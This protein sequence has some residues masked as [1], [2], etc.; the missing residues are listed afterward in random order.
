M[1]NIFTVLL[2]NHLFF[3]YVIIATIALT[4]AIMCF[5]EGNGTLNKRYFVL[6]F[7]LFSSFLYLLAF[8]DINKDLVLF[9][10]NSAKKLFSAVIIL[11][12]FYNLYFARKNKLKFYP[13]YLPLIL[14]AV[15]LFS[16]F[17]KTSG[18]INNFSPLMFILALLIIYASRY[19]KLDIVN[20]VQLIL[21]LFVSSFLCYHFNVIAAEKLFEAK[22]LTLT[23]L[24]IAFIS[25]VLIILFFYA[26][27]IFSNKILSLLDTEEVRNPEMI[28]RMKIY[29]DISYM[30][31]FV[32][33][34]VNEL[35]IINTIKIHGV[36]IFHDN[37]D[38]AVS[39]EIDT[40]Q[41]KAQ[42]IEVDE[43]VKSIINNIKDPESSRKL[44]I[45]QL[46]N[47]FLKK[48][49]QYEY[50]INSD[51]IIP[52]K[53]EGAQIYL[54][55]KLNDTEGFCIQSMCEKYKTDVLLFMNVFESL[56]KDHD[57][58]NVIFSTS[59]RKIS[60]DVMVKQIQE[61]NVAYAK[62]KEKQNKLIESER[63]I[64]L[65]QISVTLNHEINNPLALMLGVSQLIDIKKSKNIEVTK[66]EI[67]SSLKLILS[68]CYRIVE[69]IKSIRNISIPVTEKYLPDIDMI[70]LNI[71]EKKM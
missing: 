22:M 59:E 12:L 62:L 53:T 31:L 17:Y 14:S 21:V 33:S 69:I 41:N 23:S 19:H 63:W 30:E 3:S 20:F 32:G 54:F 15:I 40:L 24:T 27:K 8:L 58:K 48:I 61:V 2:E 68:Q 65:S 7:F 71:K 25:P 37:E 38:N 42:K 43:G 34:L 29:D 5:Y 57:I 67:I 49:S 60:Y 16:N 52:V 56:K 45:I 4:F 46:K 36:W 6:T 28:S 64:S 51:Y 11:V 44:F 10:I 70:K 66:D 39:L 9:D 1:N 13:L 35:N 18:F 26:K 50:F 55:V 47:D